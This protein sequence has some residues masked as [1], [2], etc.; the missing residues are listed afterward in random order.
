M[1]KNASFVRNDET[2]P[3]AKAN[4]D[5]ALQNYCEIHCGLANRRIRPLCHLSKPILAGTP[6][7]S[8]HQKCPVAGRRR[9]PFMS[10]ESDIICGKV[11]E[12]S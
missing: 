8:R 12:K 2:R 1:P 11:K 9:F 5:N 6:A 7:G 10:H 4:S 3:I